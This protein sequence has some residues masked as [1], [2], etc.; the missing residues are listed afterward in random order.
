MSADLWCKTDIGPDGAWRYFLGYIK[1]EP[2]A[3]ITL[4]V[5]EHLVTVLLSRRLLGSR[6]RRPFRY[7]MHMGMK[8]RLA[9]QHTDV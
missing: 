9:C 5:D 8:D 7:E 4:R 1:K 3:T 6:Y 2:A